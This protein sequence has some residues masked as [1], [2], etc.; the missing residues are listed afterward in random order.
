VWTGLIGSRNVAC[1]SIRALSGQF[2][3]WGLVDKSVAIISVIGGSR[4]W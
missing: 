2:G 1:P 3:L 4:K